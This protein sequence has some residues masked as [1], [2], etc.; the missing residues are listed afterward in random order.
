[1]EVLNQRA[2]VKRVKIRSKPNPFLTPEIHQ[3]RNHDQWHKLAGKTNDPLH[4]NGYRFFCQ[5]VKR[6]ICEAE[7]VHIRTQIL[8]SNG[9]S[10]S[11]WKIIDRCPPHA[12]LDSSMASEDLTG[13]ANE[14]NDL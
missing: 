4:W 5:E 7:K 1:M 12:Q 10:K 9:N 3:L 6:E 14:L 11:I 8:D 2:P 13:L